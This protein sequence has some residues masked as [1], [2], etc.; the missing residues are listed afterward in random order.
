MK[1]LL[2]FCFCLSAI[3]LFAQKP[4]GGAMGNIRIGR[5]YG[6][7]VDPTTKQPMPYASVTVLRSMPNGTDTLVGGGLSQENGDFNITQLP[8]GALKVRV[9]FMGYKELN[10]TVKISAP[11]D[12]EQDMG[13]L[14]LAPDATVL[15]AVEVRAEKASTQLSLEKR[16]FNVEKNITTVGGTAEDVLKNV[17][18]VTVD[19]DGNAKL[20][21]KATTIYIDGKLTLMSLNQIPA[22]QIESVEVISNPSAKY[23]ASATGGIVNIVMKKNTKPGYNGVLA[24]GVGNQ[25]RYNGML[26]LNLHQGKWSV[27][28]F[29]NMNSAKVPTV[30]YTHRTNFLSNGTVLNRF[31]QNTS[32]VFEN[33]FQT[34]RMNVDYALNNRNTFS[35]SGT[36][37]SGKF[38]IMPNQFYTY[39]NSEGA[40]TSY[41]V[42]Q[43]NP[44]NNFQNNNVEAQWKK[45]F[46]KKDKS[47]AVLANYSWGTGSNTAAWNTTGF[48]SLG[49]ALPNYPELVQ[50]SGDNTNQQGVFQ[51]DFANPINDS[52]KIEMGVRSFWSD[53]NQEY[54]YKP[55]QYELNQYVLDNQFS[56][57]NRITES[58][59]AAYINY[60]GNWKHQIRYQAGFRFEQSFLHGKSFLDG[61][62]SFGYDYPKGTGKDLLRSLFPALYLS[63]K[64][65]PSSEI[66]L[67]FTRKIQRPNFR[68]IMPGI[69]AADKQNYQIGNPNLQPEFVNMAELNYNKIFG[70]HNWLSTIYI[71]NETNTLKP[72]L[73][74][75]ETDPTVLVTSFV[76]GK[77]ELTWGSDNTLRMAFGKNLDVMLNANVFNFKVTVDTFTNT[78]WAVNGKANVTYR[79]PAD[80]SVQL[81]GGYEGNRPMP[82]GNRKA[83]AYM[84]FAVK[85][86]FF[87]NAANITFTISDVFN[88]RKDIAIFNQPTYTQQVMRRRDS[89]F[90][91]LSLQI[92]FGKADASMF[93]RMK[94]AKSRSQE[95]PDFSGN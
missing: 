34:G 88:S 45:T 57:Y 51:L 18:S 59:N 21:E 17:P 31:D 10:K 84:D 46:A 61:V 27:S 65:N 19:V 76:N 85:K 14:L 30:G 25:N 48:D 83:I 75:S 95:M 72:F 90:F 54:F 63:K 36:I 77:N 41:G 39:H 4:Q 89:R 40:L 8:M 28:G 91:K 13:D 60:S 78:G 74:A 81:N 12:L 6:K 50:I 53:R 70:A 15:D 7:I 73:R 9:R 92:P 43:T 62:G 11:N 67:N 55:F 42:R 66:G 87:N 38:N 33:I 23:E 64:I 49:L 93:K 32:V 22:D 79:L 5:V 26:N 94:D 68:Q 44:K 82:Q 52:T 47:L 56:Q 35:L 24:L 16:V 71:S 29:Y 20:R 2:S 1:Y 3:F 37:V 58:I 80:F 69:Q 86:S